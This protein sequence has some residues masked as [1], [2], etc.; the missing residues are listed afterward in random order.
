MPVCRDFAALFRQAAPPVRSRTRPAAPDR[1][2]SPERARV[3]AT[4]KQNDRSS[5][6]WHCILQDHRTRIH[7]SRRA[8]ASAREQALAVVFR[9]RAR[10]ISSCTRALA[11]EYPAK[12]YRLP[13]IRRCACKISKRLRLRAHSRIMRALAHVRARGTI[14]NSGI[15][16]R[17]PCEGSLCQECQRLTSHLGIFFAV[18]GYLTG[19]TGESGRSYSL[20]FGNKAGGGERALLRGF[21]RRLGLGLPARSFR[22]PCG[23]SRRLRFLS[24]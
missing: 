12:V 15:P 7:A 2:V 21:I 20:G 11:R 10:E 1:A 24:G 5:S 14:A 17:H 18:G 16:W 4:V 19:G 9:L 8:T 13:V 3:G 23:V 22:C 6:N